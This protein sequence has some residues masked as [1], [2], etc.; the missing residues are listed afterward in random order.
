VSTSQCRYDF[1]SVLDIYP[2]IETKSIVAKGAFQ[3]NANIQLFADYFWVENTT[4]YASSETPINDFV[5]NGPFIYP[6]NG[7]FYP[8]PFV[9]GGGDLIT[10]TGPLS[11]AWRG[12]D[13]GRRSDQAV[14]EAERI[15]V[16]A[17]GNFGTWDYEAA[18]VS[19][20][21][22]VTD[23]YTD[24]WLSETRARQV[25][26]TGL[27][28][29]WSITG[30]TAPAQ[31]LLDSAKILQEVRNA[32]GK[33]KSFDIRG[34]SEIMQGSAG[35]LSLA[36]GLET[37]KEEYNDNPSA[38]QSS[39]DILG[40]GGNQ[41]VASGDRNVTAVFLELN[42]P[43][44]KEV[45]AI[46]ALRSDRYSDFGSSTNPKIAMRW[47]PDKAVLLTLVVEDVDGW[48]ARLADAGVLNLTAPRLHEQVG[49]YGF[50]AQDPGG[51]KLEF[52]RF[53]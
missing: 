26:G 23:T 4:D 16:G 39:G 49:V 36:V 42:W 44:T 34:S 52:Q 15:V 35:P 8:K 28:N 51:Y 13:T 40:G 48:H 45:E 19:A 21:S 47:T 46:F 11:I 27:V 2:P 6:A 7:P 20:E 53:V 10:P 41:P 33:V 12:K 30:Q 43:I 29:L 32:T 1:T 50:F 31:A 37:R 17:R 25:I 14:S 38:I 3:V 18:F 22:K 24:G 9:T 5:G